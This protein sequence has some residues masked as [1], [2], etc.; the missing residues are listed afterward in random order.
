MNLRTHRVASAA[1]RLVEG[2]KNQLTREQ[3]KKYGAIAHKLP[4]MILQNGLSQATGFLLAKSPRYPE[5]G[6]LLEDLNHTLRAGGTLDRPDL[7]TLHQAIIEANLEQTL[8]YTRHA[9]EATGWL[10]RYV[11]GVLRV[12]ATGEDSTEDGN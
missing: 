4:G 10:K 7:E 6:Y 3:Q 9:L 11:Q 5:H 1:Y 12:D 2:R 8:K